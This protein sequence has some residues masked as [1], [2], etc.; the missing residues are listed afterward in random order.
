MIA[1]WIDRLLIAITGSCCPEA[2]DQSC[3]CNAPDIINGI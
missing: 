2:A 1:N 3:D